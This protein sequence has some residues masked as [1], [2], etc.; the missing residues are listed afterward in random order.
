MRLKI[1]YLDVDKVDSLPN[2]MLM[3]KGRMYLISKCT[4]TCFF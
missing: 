3:Y 2:S 1:S 4:R